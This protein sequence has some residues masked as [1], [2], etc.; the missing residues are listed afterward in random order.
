MGYKIFQG[1][2]LPSSLKDPPIKGLTVARAEA[3]DGVSANQEF[4]LVRSE[5]WKHLKNLG[6]VFCLN[7]RNTG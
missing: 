6:D 2:D 7:R 1:K 3:T 5:D 4:A